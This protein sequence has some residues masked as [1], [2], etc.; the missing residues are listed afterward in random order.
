[1]AARIDE[2]IAII[3]KEQRLEALKQ[4]PNFKVGK[5]HIFIKVVLPQHGINPLKEKN[6]IHLIS[7]YQNMT[8]LEVKKAIDSDNLFFLPFNSWSKAVEANH[9][10]KELGVISQIVKADDVI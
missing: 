6:L 2:K 4:F 3:E 7:E 10:I 9:R 5:T 8:A 1:M